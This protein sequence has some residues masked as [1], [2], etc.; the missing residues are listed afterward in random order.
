MGKHGDKLYDSLVKI[1]IGKT[2]LPNRRHQ[3]I[4]EPLSIV[5]A[6]LDV[7]FA[8]ILNDLQSTQNNIKSTYNNEEDKKIISILDHFDNSSSPV[9]AWRLIKELYGK[10]KSSN[11]FI[12]G[13]DR[14]S[15]WKNHFQ[16]LL[17]NVFTADTE[18]LPSYQSYI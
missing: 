17:N 7:L 3:A 12:A 16:S 5:R 8:S 9:N 4:S 1:A 10:K 18:D 14:L 6:R 13:D 2:N 11:C 15:I